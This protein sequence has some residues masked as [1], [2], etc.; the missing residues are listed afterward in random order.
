MSLLNLLL[1]EVEKNGGIAKTYEAV[2][3]ELEKF[4][5]D[6]RVLPF[7]SRTTCKV[8]NIATG[9]IYKN[10]SVAA[11]SVKAN[12]NYFQKRIRKDGTYLSFIKVA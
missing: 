3:L 10:C 4:E 12:V 7:H 5:K 6:D 1:H 11:R 2:S 8:M 9:K